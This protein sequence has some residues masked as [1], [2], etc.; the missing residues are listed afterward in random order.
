[1]GTRVQRCFELL[2][3]SGNIGAI[4][5]EKLNIITITRGSAADGILLVSEM[6]GIE[7]NQ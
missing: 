7:M 5:D 6:M 4:T 1:M 2:T 3:E